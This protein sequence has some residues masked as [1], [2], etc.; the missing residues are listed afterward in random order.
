MHYSNLIKNEKLGY[1][2]IDF[3]LFTISRYSVHWILVLP[4]LTK[5]N[6]LVYGLNGWNLHTFS[7]TNWKIMWF[8][9]C[10]TEMPSIN[11]CEK[12]C[13]DDD[14]IVLYHWNFAGSWRSFDRTYFENYYCWLSLQFVYCCCRLSLSSSSS[15]SS[16]TMFA[17]YFAY[18]HHE[19]KTSSK[20]EN[21]VFLFSWLP[22]HYP[23]STDTYNAHTQTAIVWL[24]RPRTHTHTHGQNTLTAQYKRTLDKCCW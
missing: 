4:K 7:H 19:R 2:R 12:C 8:L 14:S 18:T 16:F 13:A 20:V 23:R 5:R 11:F 6:F 1:K 17:V 22:K 21:S 9:V 24:V 3:W 10:N 15:S